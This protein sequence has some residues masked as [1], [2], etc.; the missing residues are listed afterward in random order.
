VENPLTSSQTPTIGNVTEVP[1]DQLGCGPFRGLAQ[2]IE[3]DQT[4]ALNGDNALNSA[5]QHCWWWAIGTSATWP[6]EGIPSYMAPPG[7]QGTT[8]AQLWVR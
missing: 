3:A 6:N 4:S 7:G 1:A 2:S 8:Q 5:G